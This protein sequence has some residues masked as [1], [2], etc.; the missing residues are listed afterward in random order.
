VTAP[1]AEWPVSQHP[2]YVTQ[3]GVAH[4]RASKRLS[5]DS[6]VAKR[7]ASRGRSLGRILACLALTLAFADAA[8][9]DG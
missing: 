2:N 1:F 3:E 5:Q 9:A 4:S 7:D 6:A 8:I